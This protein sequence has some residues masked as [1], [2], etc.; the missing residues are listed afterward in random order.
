VAVGLGNLLSAL[1]TTES[2]LS[3]EV[4]EFSLGIRGYRDIENVLHWVKDVV[5][6]E[7]RAPFGRHN[8]ATN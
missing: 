2:S 1:A 8:R 7:D 5:L 4:A 6:A 3:V